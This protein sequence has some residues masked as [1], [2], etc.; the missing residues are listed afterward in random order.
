MD[1]L[2]VDMAIGNQLCKLIISHPQSFIHFE[3]DSKFLTKV[4]TQPQNTRPPYLK[5]WKQSPPW[6]GND[7]SALTFI[8]IQPVPQKKKGKKKHLHHHQIQLLNTVLNG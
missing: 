2:G 7:K 4:S 8:T 3:P 5:I 1:K 6:F